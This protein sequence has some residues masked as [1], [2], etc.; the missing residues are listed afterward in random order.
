MMPLGLVEAV[1]IEADR[2]SMLPKSGYHFSDNSML[3]VLES[4]TFMRF[5]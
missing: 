4:I 5:D 1:T 3:N 2:Q